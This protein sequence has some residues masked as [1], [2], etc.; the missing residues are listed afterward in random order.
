M[1]KI[2]YPEKFT[3]N[4]IIS[5]VAKKNGMTKIKVK[6]IYEDFFD[7]IGQGVL[8]GERVPIADLGKMF[9]RVKPAT[10]ERKGRN[11]LT[12]QEI[13]ISAKPASN[14]PKFSFGKN[15]KEAVSKIKVK[16]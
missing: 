5:A 6:S 1:S 13:T 10:K 8:K 2:N 14:T 4:N 15:F 11:P 3:I 7:C 9:I 16:K 12:G